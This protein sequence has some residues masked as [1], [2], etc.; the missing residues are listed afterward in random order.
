M[1]ISLFGINFYFFVSFVL[2]DDT[3]FFSFVACFTFDLFAAHDDDE[4][5]VEA[6]LDDDEDPAEACIRKLY[7]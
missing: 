5:P 1:I 7:I 6:E 4:D 3:D 2:L